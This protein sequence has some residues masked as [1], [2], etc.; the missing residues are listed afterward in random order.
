MGETGPRHRTHP[1]R[2]ARGALMTRRRRALHGLEDDIRDHLER[3]IRDLIG[4][5]MT[6]E[7]AHAAAL[8][9]FG[10]VARTLEETRAVW[11]REWFE[12]AGQDVRYALR[13]LRRNPRFAAVVVVT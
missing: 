2:G 8:R 4:R 7:A 5:G 11:R 13:F 10:N 9:K 12:Q 1:H 6:P 3:E